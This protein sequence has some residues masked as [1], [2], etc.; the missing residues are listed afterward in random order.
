MQVT[1]SDSFIALII[2]HLIYFNKSKCSCD[3]LGRAVLIWTTY[4]YAIG[5]KNEPCLN[6]LVSEWP[7]LSITACCSRKSLSLPVSLPRLWLEHCLVLAAPVAAGP[8]FPA[9]RRTPCHLHGKNGIPTTSQPANSLLASFQT[10]SLFWPKS[11]KP[12]SVRWHSIFTVIPPISLKWSPNSEGQ[13]VSL[14]L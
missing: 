10:L 8:R 12:W 2:S 11:T 4:S 3:E 9:Q 7:P 14:A 5:L 13:T 1:I 6:T